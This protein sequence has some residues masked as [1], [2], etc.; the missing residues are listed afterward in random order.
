MHTKGGWLGQTSAENEGQS[1]E[2]CFPNHD[3]MNAFLICRIGGIN[4]TQF[5]VVAVLTLTPPRYV[6]EWIHNHCQKLNPAP[7][8]W[9]T[10]SCSDIR[11]SILLYAIARYWLSSLTSPEIGHGHFTSNVTLTLITIE[12]KYKHHE[13]NS[14]SIPPSIISHPPEATLQGVPHAVQRSGPHPNRLP[15]RPLS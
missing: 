12:C 2:R 6:A 11:N 14:F 8:A 1:Y 3:T 7:A 5:V 13:G 10:L 4:I 9:S 15:T